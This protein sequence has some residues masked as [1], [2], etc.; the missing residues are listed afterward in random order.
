MLIINP[1]TEEIIS[2]VSEDTSETLALKFRKLKA[3]RPRWSSTSIPGR[4]KILLRFS[5]LM[6]EKIEQLALVLTN[7]VGKPIQ[8]SRNEI[9]GGRARI[10]WLA[11]NSEKYLGDEQMTK[12]NSLE[13]KISYD[14]LGTIC[15][16]SAWNYPWLVGINVFVS[17]LLAGNAVMYKPS[18]YAILT[19]LEIEKLFQQSGLPEDLFHVALGAGSV[20]KSLLPLPFDGYFFTGSFKTGK[21][22]YEHCASRM[23]PCQ[24]EMGG[25]DPVYIADDVA[26]IEQVAAST[27]DGAFYN[28]GQSCCS[29]ERIYVEEPVYDKYLTAFVKEILSWK[30]GLPTEEGIYFGPITRKDQ[31]VVLE[32]QV[33]DAISK[34]ARL[35][36]GGKRLAGKGY[37]FEP[38]ILVDVTHD[39]DLMREESFGP[40]IG[41]MKVKDDAEATQLMADTEYGLTAA[42]YSR[43]RERA[44]K[45]LKQLNTG[46]G[47][48][49]CCDRVS[50]PLPWSGRHHSGFGVTLSHAGLHSFVRPK[51]WHLRSGS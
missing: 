32:K 2:E 43:D 12:E 33:A 14:P 35:I 39:M 31:L 40:I 16:I 23:I 36:M 19:G 6:G 9:N 7:E 34:G 8:Q 21:S 49:N 11:E 29:V 20:G 27:A 28:N 42:V 1:A 25:K 3:A 44:E 48:W 30:T 17:A 45:I 10:K 37:Y 13:E 47:Y 41:I 38:T 15:N 46:S 5:D 50:A 22:I 18:E 51:A 4:K 26:S 24:L